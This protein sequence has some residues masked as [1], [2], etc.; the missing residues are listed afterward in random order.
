MGKRRLAPPGAKTPPLTA[1]LLDTDGRTAAQW[2]LLA[3]RLHEAVAE[4]AEALAA[5]IRKTAAGRPPGWLKLPA[6][7]TLNVGDRRLLT[8][9]ALH[10]TA[11]MTDPGSP[12]TAA[13]DWDSL[14]T[15]TD[16]AKNSRLEKTSWTSECRDCSA[17]RRIE[18]SWTS[19]EASVSYSPPAG[20]DTRG[21]GG[22]S[23]ALLSVS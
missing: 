6:R 9:I 5:N 2:E 23:H 3:Y 18:I 10:E 17:G 15:G 11:C 7:L 20:T 22:L 14:E 21:R 13:H 8:V 12:S 4:T 1:A 16:I 19:R